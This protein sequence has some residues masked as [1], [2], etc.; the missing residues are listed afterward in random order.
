MSWQIQR[1]QFLPQSLEEVFPFFAQAENLNQITPPW[2]R[3]RL[4]T[5]LPIVMQQGTLIDYKIRWR[6]WPIRWRTE[7][8]E[9][10]PP[11]GF[12]DVQIKG[13]YRRWHHRHTFLSQAG[14]TLV[15]D[16]VEYDLP[17][18]FLGRWL[19]QRVI[20]SDLE[21]IFDYRARRVADYFNASNISP[22]LIGYLDGF[23]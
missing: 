23:Q 9:W 2:L 19:H 10:N 13:P 22:S 3:F 8:V 6:W 12:V 20:R 17:L 1:E 14:G 7:I 21:A 4:L 11:H 5:P 16:E 15:R 18:G